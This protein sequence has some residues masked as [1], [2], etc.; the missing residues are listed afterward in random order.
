MKIWKIQ[1]L[2]HT[3]SSGES[4]EFHPL[5]P[6]LPFCSGCSYVQVSCSWFQRTVGGSPSTK[7]HPFPTLWT[8]LHFLLTAKVPRANGHKC[9]GLKQYSPVIH[10]SSGLFGLYSLFWLQTY[11]YRSVALA[12]VRR[13]FLFFC[14]CKSNEQIVKHKP[15]VLFDSCLPDY[16]QAWK[17]ISPPFTCVAWLQI[18]RPL[19]AA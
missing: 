9:V 8:R 4:F 17:E 12:H 3:S 14:V 7:G 2:C 18:S 19:C 16:W 15:A 13:P 1:F 10:F 5:L 11:R 6:P